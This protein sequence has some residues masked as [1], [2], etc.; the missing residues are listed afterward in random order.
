MKK[1]YGFQLRDGKGT[2]TRW[3]STDGKFEGEMTP[4][5]KQV[6]TTQKFL[7]F[8]AAYAASKAAA[9]YRDIQ[10]VALYEDDY[11]KLGNPVKNFLKKIF[12]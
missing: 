9:R 2:F 4:E 3:F 8:H 11:K 1:A 5:M 10:F 7:V 12:R 6:I